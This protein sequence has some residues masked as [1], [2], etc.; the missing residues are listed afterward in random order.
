MSLLPGIKPDV[1]SFI[2]GSVRCFSRLF[3]KLHFTRIPRADRPYLA[4]H[5]RV[6]CEFNSSDLHPHLNGII[7]PDYGFWAKHKVCRLGFEYCFKHW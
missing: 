6:E 7:S 1:Y 5:P 2:N 4:L 3:K